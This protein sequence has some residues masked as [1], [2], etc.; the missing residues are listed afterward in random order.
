MTACTRNT[1]TDTCP[2]GSMWVN[3][4][5]VR[6]YIQNDPMTNAWTSPSFLARDH[7]AG[8]I[9]KLCQ[10][11]RKKRRMQKISWVK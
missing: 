2:G 10:S 7:L 4:W 11:R 1:C 3:V 5:G 9:S 8:Y 6:V